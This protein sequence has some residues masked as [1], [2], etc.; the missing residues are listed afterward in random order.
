MHRRANLR[1][2]VGSEISM[3]NM[4]NFMSQNGF[5]LRSLPRIKITSKK[6]SWLPEA[7]RGGRSNLRRLQHL[8]LAIAADFLTQ[9]PQHRHR[10]IG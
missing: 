10:T 2:D 7:H 1:N 3:V 6:D 5:L 4:S 9:L 8:N